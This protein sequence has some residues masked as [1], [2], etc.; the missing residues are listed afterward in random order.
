M[1]FNNIKSEALNLRVSPAL[2][3][4]LKEGAEYEKSKK[5]NILKVLS[6]EYFDCNAIVTPSQKTTSLEHKRARADC[7]SYLG[8]PT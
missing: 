8:A 3:Q 1:R 4:V 2:K 6:K 7:R 5:V